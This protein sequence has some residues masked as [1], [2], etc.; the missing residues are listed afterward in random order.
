MKA[1]D[2]E[3]VIEF[4]NDVIKESDRIDLTD[5]DLEF[6]HKTNWFAM[7]MLTNKF[8]EAVLSMKDAIHKTIK[9]LCK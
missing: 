7:W 6:I 3:N 4:Y 5:E 8:D 9:N 1:K 2:K